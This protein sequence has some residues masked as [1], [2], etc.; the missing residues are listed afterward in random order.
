MSRTYNGHIDDRKKEDIGLH[1]DARSRIEAIY[2]SLGKTLTPNSA[3]SIMKECYHWTD[4]DG[5]KIQVIAASASNSENGASLVVENRGIEIWDKKTRRSRYMPGRIRS[6]KADVIFFVL[7]LE[8]LTV[9]IVEVAP[10]SLIDYLDRFSLAQQSLSKY[11]EY[12]SKKARSIAIENWNSAFKIDSK[13]KTRMV[14]PITVNEL[15]GISNKVSLLHINNLPQESLTHL[16]GKSNV[17]SDIA[18]PASSK[19]S[20]KK[21]KPSPISND[22]EKAET[23]TSSKMVFSI[24]IES[25][26]T[27]FST[28]N[29]SIDKIRKIVDILIG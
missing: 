17:A 6:S 27:K 19:R 5:Y 11:P 9:R 10:K 14:T 13:G 18:M 20:V 4:S 1:E 25:G 29:I 28:S 24:N 7:Y 16:F 15:I 26:D 2:K 3:N 21:T 23:A 22:T 8:D 12:A